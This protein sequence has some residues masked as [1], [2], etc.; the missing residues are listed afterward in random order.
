MDDLLAQAG[1]SGEVDSHSSPNPGEPNT[2]P[3]QP[4]IVDVR[5]PEEFSMQAVPGAVNIPLNELP[6]RYEELQPTDRE[7]I[8]YCASGARS[9]YA[10][11]L[12]GQLGFTQVENGGSLRE[13][14]MRSR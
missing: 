2:E 9:S 10:Q 5:T 8:V 14:M 13:M 4:I 3:S 1:S 11:M 6:G 7:I 12:L